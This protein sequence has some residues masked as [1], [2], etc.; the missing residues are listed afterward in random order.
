MSK[1]KYMEKPFALVAIGEKFDF[2]EDVKTLCFTASPWVKR[3][4]VSYS[5]DDDPEREDWQSLDNLSQINALCVVI[6]TAEQERLD[7]L[8]ALDLNMR[9]VR[10]LDEAERA[11][12]KVFRDAA[13]QLAEAKERYQALQVSKDLLGMEKARLNQKYY[14]SIGVLEATRSDLVRLQGHVEDGKNIL[15]AAGVAGVAFSALVYF[16]G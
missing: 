10:R 14:Q 6:D 2:R 15:L 9:L 12:D 16:M 1:T 5:C 8:E 11:R 3:D 7:K 13:K 4:S